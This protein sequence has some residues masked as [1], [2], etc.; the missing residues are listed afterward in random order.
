MLR[1]EKGDSE[2]E[3]LDK[4]RLMDEKHQNEMQEAEAAFQL[5]IMQ[6]V[7]GYQVH[8]YPSPF[9][10]SDEKLGLLWLKCPCMLPRCHHLL[11]LSSLPPALPWRGRS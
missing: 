2:V 9:Y 8:V 1:E 4:L 11:S 3:Y 10:A 6:L 5:K 7:D